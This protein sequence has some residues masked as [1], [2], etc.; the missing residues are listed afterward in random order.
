MPDLWTFRLE[1]LFSDSRPVLD[2]KYD[3]EKRVRQLLPR[4]HERPALVFRNTSRSYTTAGGSTTIELRLEAACDTYNVYALELDAVETSDPANEKRWEQNLRGAFARW[5]Q[6]LAP[7]ETGG[8]SS[9]D[10]YRQVMEE[11]IA[12]E[13]ELAHR[14]NPQEEAAIR[15]IQ[16]TILQGLRGGQRFS[17]AHHEGGTNIRFLGPVFVLQDYG[18]SN[19]REEFPSSAEF[20]ARLR[21]FYDGEAR[22]DWYPHAPPELEAWRFI[23]SEMRP[24]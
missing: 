15:V 7:A 17:T 20:L 22:R 5:T 19:D 4:D 1:G 2:V 23:L 14:V 18:E 16:E 6:G 9:P 3:I 13:F 24:G 8:S 21:K 12:R 10:R 11:T